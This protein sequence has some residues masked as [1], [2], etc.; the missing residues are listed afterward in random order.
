MIQVN[1]R[2]IRP[3]YVIVVNKLIELKNQKGP[4]V[5]IDEILKFWSEESPK[6]WKSV[7]TTV[8]N[9]KQTRK[10]T[11]VG[12]KQFSG[13]SR[14]KVTGGLLRYQLDVPLKVVHMIR[15]IYKEEELPMDKKFFNKF[16]KRY[17]RFVISE[18]K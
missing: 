10:V 1:V 14:D 2:K 11:N 13:V 16:A 18:T 3:K 17:P 8:K 7:I 4:W 9:R 6:E 12:N 5:V 15:A